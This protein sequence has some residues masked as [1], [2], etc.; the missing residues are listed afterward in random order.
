MFILVL[1]YFLLFLFLRLWISPFQVCYTWLWED[2][3][4]KYSKE[5]ADYVHYS[6]VDVLKEQLFLS[7]EEIHS[8]QTQNL[9]LHL[10]LDSLNKQLDDKSARL[11]QFQNDLAELKK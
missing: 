3:L 11:D 2:Q 8:L 7:Q 6:T 9:S 5:L 1:F 10:T 4:R